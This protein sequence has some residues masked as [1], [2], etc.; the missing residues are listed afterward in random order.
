MIRLAVKPSFIY[1]LLN[2]LKTYF[3]IHNVADSNGK[4][5]T[6]DIFLASN[7][8]CPPP[9]VLSVS[10]T[11]TAWHLHGLVATF[12]CALSFCNWAAS[13]VAARHLLVV[14][15]NCTHTAAAPA[16][17]TFES[18]SFVA[19]LL[20]DLH[21]STLRVDLRWWKQFVVNVTASS[22]NG[23]VVMWLIPPTEMM[24]LL[25]VFKRQLLTLASCCVFCLCFVILLAGLYMWPTTTLLLI[26]KCKKKEGK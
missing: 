17:H 22:P 18:Q 6:L 20:S 21:T 25:L 16:F 19:W 12:S 5:L 7:A 9:S 26:W 4:N 14:W 8:C 11:D 2:L 23:L 24:I 3:G 1:L 15:G 13:L 10:C